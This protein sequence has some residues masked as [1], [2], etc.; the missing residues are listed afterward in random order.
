MTE[1]MG[2]N[3]FY[4][5]VGDW[6]LVNATMDI[7]D[8]IV[9]TI[10]GG[11]EVK[12]RVDMAQF[13]GLATFTKAWIGADTAVLLVATDVGVTEATM[14]ADFDAVTKF[15]YG[16]ITRVEHHANYVIL[17]AKQMVAKWL[18]EPIQNATNAVSTT[19]SFVTGRNATTV[20]VA[21]ATSIGAAANRGLRLTWNSVSP[22]AEQTELHNANTVA[23]KSGLGSS[24]GTGTI[25]NLDADD[26]S[27]CMYCEYH[28]SAD[29]HAYCEIRFGSLMYFPPREGSM[30]ITLDYCMFNDLNADYGGTTIVANSVTAYNVKT[31]AWDVLVSDDKTY[32]E[33]TVTFALSNDYIDTTN[34][35]M[36][37]IKVDGGRYQ[38]GTYKHSSFY[39]D[40]AKLDYTPGYQ[41]DPIEYKI[42]DV[43]G[44]VI[45]IDD[46]NPLSDWTNIGDAATV[47]YTEKEFLEDD[48][49]YGLSQDKYDSTLS[50]THFVPATIKPTYSLFRWGAINNFATSVNR[51][52]GTFYYPTRHTTGG[53]YDIYFRAT[54][55]D[56]GLTI[57]PS[58]TDGE[59]FSDAFDRDDKCRAVVVQN[60]ET[61]AARSS[62]GDHLGTSLSAALPSNG[63]QAIPLNTPELPDNYLLDYATSY[64]DYRNEIGDDIVVPVRTVLINDDV[65]HFNA[66]PS[67]TSIDDSPQWAPYTGDDSDGT[68]IYAK[69][70]DTSAAFHVDDGLTDS[71]VKLYTFPTASAAT[72]THS[73]MIDLD[74][75]FDADS[76]CNMDIILADGSANVGIW[77]EITGTESTKVLKVLSSVD[78]WHTTTGA[79]VSGRCQFNITMD[80]DAQTFT[81]YQWLE[82]VWTAIAVQG[83]YNTLFAATGA[84]TYM[85]T[86]VEKGLNDTYFYDITPSWGGIGTAV[87]SAADDKLHVGALVHL[88][89]APTTK[90]GIDYQIDDDYIIRSIKWTK[91]RQA[92]LSLGNAIATAQS[93]EQM[94]DEILTRLDHSS[95]A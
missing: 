40:Y 62:V 9:D 25:A 84:I 94:M 65:E 63:L 49:V 14:N 21:N 53:E 11:T 30:K 28:A 42:T 91:D 74:T 3:W 67:G 95:T 38:G 37:K 66:Y 93:P 44:N 46:G 82:G 87:R 35:D 58:C 1:T 15:F 17:K 7:Y 71:V 76:A 72:G 33:H 36:V 29:V 69:F 75:H 88:H 31:G 32:P 92:V 45:T 90:T 77:F 41:H 23:Y 6:H 39:I 86:F 2:F 64:Y 60:K 59:D 89:A 20:T 19:K 50:C 79:D 13:S 43:T 78:G 55:E 8:D 81:F 48:T 80:L 5:A 24:S 47:L 85:A 22:S 10:N 56:T 4:G 18:G 57:N 51:R 12:V 61:W 70:L 73:V 34:Y 83:G 16:R 54:G 68:T 27:D 52:N 26:G